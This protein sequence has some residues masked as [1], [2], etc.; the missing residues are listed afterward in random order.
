MHPD[1]GKE[2]RHSHERV[3]G[4]MAQPELLDNPVDD[5][6]QLNEE[7]LIQEKVSTEGQK[8]NACNVAGSTHT[9]WQ[10]TL[11]WWPPGLTTLAPGDIF[12]PAS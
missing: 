6:P 5:C 10:L 9:H 2:H 11:Q 12:P 1:S 8:G 3:R 7:Q 4:N